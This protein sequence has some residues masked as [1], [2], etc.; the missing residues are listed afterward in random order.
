M[1]A[2]FRIH[3][4]TMVA[5]LAAREA[6]YRHIAANHPA[7]LKFL[8]GWLNRNNNVLRK[9]ISEPATKTQIA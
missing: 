7:S 2:D 8:G 6:L 9:L 5:M 4:Q 3:W 1:P